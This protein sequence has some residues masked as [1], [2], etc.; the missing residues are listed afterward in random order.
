M[1]SRSQSAVYVRKL[2]TIGTPC[3][4]SNATETVL[5]R[6]AIWVKSAAQL[7]LGSVQ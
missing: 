6:V 4:A 3:F 2:F 1:R 7:R 5:G